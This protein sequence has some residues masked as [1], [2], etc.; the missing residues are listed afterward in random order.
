MTIEYSHIVHLIAKKSKRDF[1]RVEDSMR[2]IC[3]DLREHTIEII[4]CKKQGCYPWQKKERENHTANSIFAIYAKKNLMMIIMMKIIVR[5]E[6]A[7]VTH[8]N[9]VLSHVVSVI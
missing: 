5:F 6:T 3:V 7:L 4:D 1:H 9:I 8:E 2:K